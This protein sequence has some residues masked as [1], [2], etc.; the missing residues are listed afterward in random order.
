[1]RKC[2][3]RLSLLAN[4]DLLNFQSTL[5]LWS[6]LLVARRCLSATVT[7]PLSLLAQSIV[8]AGA[9]FGQTLYSFYGS[10]G[11]SHHSVE[12]VGIRR[13]DG[14]EAD[15]ITHLPGLHYDPGFEQFAGYINVTDSRHIFYWYVESQSDPA[16]D[17]VVLWTK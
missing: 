16:N 1:M 9:L 5:H 17:P 14:A 3:L 11:G 12:H 13:S 15:R 8:S 4:L 7:M 6:N 10:W 2:S